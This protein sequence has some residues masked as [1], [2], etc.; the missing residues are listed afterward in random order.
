MV[1][2][3]SR[4]M[5]RVHGTAAIGARRSRWESP[6]SLRYWHTSSEEATG[7]SPICETNDN[8]GVDDPKYETLVNR[9][10]GQYKPN[11]IANSHPVHHESVESISDDS[12]YSLL[13]EQFASPSLPTRADEAI[14]QVSCRKKARSQDIAIVGMSCRFPGDATDP[15]KLW[16]L[17][18]QGREA[19]STWPTD[20]FNQ[21]AFYHP[22]PERGGNFNAKGGHFLNQVVA[23]FDASFFNITPA[24]AKAL[25]PQ[26]RLQ[27]ESTYE[28]LE[29]AGISLDTIAGSDTG[30]FIG[31]SNHDY[32][33]MLWKDPDGLPLYHAVGVS[34]S[35]MANRISY[36]F[37]LRGPSITVDTACSS[38]LV[39]LH[40][41]CQSLRSGEASQA[42]V[43]GTN[44]ILE[45]GM[46]IP[47]SSLKFF[48][49][50]GKCYTYDARAEGYGRG[51]GV[52]TVIIKLLDDAVRDGDTIRC[53]VRATGVNSD[54]RTAGLMLPNGDAQECLIR[55]TYASANLDPK[56]TQY[57]ESHGTGTKAGDPIESDVIGRIFGTPS[58]STDM[59]SVR[60]GSVKSN[61]GHLE[62]AS[63][64]AGLIKS[65]LSVERG[66]ILPNSNFE[67]PGDRIVL[68]ERNLRVPTRLEPWPTLGLRRSSVNSFG[69]GGT[70]AHCVID[71]AE[72][73][74]RLNGIFGHSLR[75]GDF[76]QVSSQPETCVE[77]RL[78]IYV[79]SANDEGT[80]HRYANTLGAHLNQSVQRHHQYADQL[81]YT[82]NS[83]R[84]LLPWRSAVVASS[85]SGLSQKLIHDDIKPQRCSRA[86]NLGFVFT[87]QG[88]Q[89]YGMGR[90]LLDAYPVYRR[91]IEI[92]S[93]HFKS[94]G[95]SWSLIE[96]L[97]RDQATSKL[98]YSSISQPVCTAVQLAIVDLLASWEIQPS[99]V[100]GHSS[101]EIAAAYAAG[102]LDSKSALAIAY[103]RGKAMEDLKR[104]APELRGTMLAAGISVSQA[105]EFIAKMGPSD[106]TVACI[107]SPSSVTISGD[108]E[109][110]E[111]MGQLLVDHK[112]FARRLNV[113]VAYHSDHMLYTSNEYL[114]NLLAGPKLPNNLHARQDVTFVSSLE[115]R[116]LDVSELGA[117]YWVR[118]MVSPVRF[119][120][121]LAEL[122]RGDEE[123]H[124]DTLIEVGPHS[125]LAG[126]IRQTLETLEL[127]KQVA[128][129]PT[130]IRYQNAHGSLLST[131]CDLWKMACP[132]DMN[133]VNRLEYPETKFGP[134]TDLPPYPFNHTI[135][136]WH[137]S[138]LSKA[139]R[140][141]KHGR[142]DL[143][144]A[145][146]P[147]SNPIEPKWRNVLRLTDVPWLKHHI[148]QSTVVYPAA[149]Y[150]AMAIEA[151]RQRTLMRSDPDTCIAQ[152]RLRNVSLIS[153]LVVPSGDAG[154]EVSL[155][156][157][158][159]SEGDR[160]LSNVWSEFMILSY[161]ESQ[162]WTEHCRGQIAA[163]VESRRS[164]RTEDAAMACIDDDCWLLKLQSQFQNCN[165]D[166]DPDNLYEMFE[167]MGLVFGSTFRNLKFVSV[168]APKTSRCGIIVPD[169][170]ATMPHRAEFFNTIHPAVLDSCFQAA[171]PVLMHDH[172]LSHPM[173]PTFI[174]QL[175][176]GS[177]A[178][179]DVGTKLKA[180]ATTEPLI[181]R[182]AVSDIAVFNVESS[183]MTRPTVL[184]KGLKTTALTWGSTPQE[185]EVRRKICYKMQYEPDIDF[186][187]TSDRSKFWPAPDSSREHQAAESLVIL[188]WLAF[189]YLSEC[190]K[191]IDE[192][193]YLEMPEH[194][195]RLYKWCR[196][197]APP[198]P[199]TKADNLSLSEAYSI[200][201]MPGSPA[202]KQAAIDFAQKLGAEGEIVTRVGENL[203]CILKGEVD[204]LSLMVQ[205]NLLTQVYAEDRSMLRCYELLQKYARSLCFKNPNMKIMEIGAGTGGATQPLL[206][207]LSTRE[208]EAFHP[209]FASYTYTDIS[210]AFFEKARSRFAA[211]D[212]VLEYRNLNIERSAAEQG[213]YEGTYD[214][215]VAA[216]VLHA[217]ANM[218]VTISNVRK[219]LRPGGRLI[220]IEITHPRLRIFLPFGTLPGWW[221]GEE[222]GR[223]MGP[224]LNPGQWSDV[225]KR[226]GFDGLDVCQADYPGP[227]EMSSLIVSRATASKPE[228]VGASPI[229][230]LTNSDQDPLAI[231]LRKSIQCGGSSSLILS[232][233]E[234]EGRRPESLIIL[235]TQ[236]DGMLSSLD[237][238]RFTK[239][240][241]TLRNSKGAVWVT[242]GATETRPAMALVSGLARTLR[243]EDAGLRL[244]TVDLDPKTIMDVTKARGII[245][246]VLEKLNDHE[247]SKDVEV[248][249]HD[250]V[251]CVPRLNAL[252]DL[253]HILT[254]KMTG[255]APLPRLEPLCQLNRP[256]RLQ[257]GNPG[258]IDSLHF[259]DVP[260]WEPH[261]DDGCVEVQVKAIGLNFRDVLTVLGQIENPYPLGYDSSGVITAVGR[262]V[263]D[264]AVGDR[265]AALAVGSFT[266]VHRVRAHN[267]FHL[268]PGIS[269][270][271]GASIPL[272]FATA[273]H[274]LVDVAHVSKGQKVL[275][276]SAAGGVGQAAI[277]LAQLASAEIFVTVGSKEK[278]QL[279]LEEY[280][281]PESHIFS[282]R[283]AGFAERIRLMTDGKGVDVVLNSLAGELMKES[284]NCIAMFG[285][286]L[287]IGKRDIYSN[288]RL[289][290]R[291]FDNHVTFAAIDLSA[292]FTHRPEWGA[293]ILGNCFKL[294]H[295]G[296]LSVMKPVTTFSIDQVETAFRH[297]QA[298][299]HSGKIVVTVPEG[300]HV[301]A[302]PMA[303]SSF[304]EADATYII[305]GGMG[306]LGREICQ[307]MVDNGAENILILSRSGVHENEKARDLLDACAAKGANVKVCK[308]DARDATA[309]AKILRDSRDK[310]CMPPIRGVI[311]G[312]MVLRDSLFE[313]MAFDD[314]KT[315]TDTKVSST[316]NLH[317]A[318]QALDSP[319]DFFILLSS[320]SGISG[321]RGQSNYAAASTFQ[322]AFARHRRSLGLP[323]TTLDLGMIASAGYV[324]DN[325][326]SV[327]YLRAHGYSAIELEE[328]FGML[329]Y[330]MTQRPQSATDSTASGSVHECQIISGYDAT[331]ATHVTALSSAVSDT[332]TASHRRAN[333]GAGASVGLADPKFSHLPH[334][335]HQRSPPTLRHADPSSSPSAFSSAE[336]SL[337]LRQALLATPRGPART[338]VLTRALATRL[339]ALLGKSG[340][341]A[342][343]DPGR[344]VAMLGVDSLVAVELRN[345]VVGET[346]VGVPVFE[347]LGAK[348]LVELS[349]RIEGACAFLGDTG[350]G[351][352]RR[353]DSEDY[354]D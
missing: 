236:G 118:N 53:V 138:R 63:G 67:K 199:P 267:V 291:P 244:M 119:T 97:S 214:L 346:G 278:R 208:G 285:F 292:V 310:G 43:G 249:E 340:G 351:D 41:A 141:R 163:D 179:R 218:D 212:D 299:K 253:N 27:L 164:E 221:L 327:A 18:A 321:N 202:K 64:I 61:I 234:L 294:F 195:K 117:S 288:T 303:E 329:R 339:A 89:W 305:A 256:L 308:C 223:E 120:E 96:E 139:Y 131:A 112:L 21:D 161:T 183:V 85:I 79:I 69:F 20:R 230:I 217:T 151:A 33:H 99:A 123:H 36:F 352:G 187:S 51:E 248:I 213:L 233:N 302:A 159:A 111:K 232:W 130:L 172:R 188:E 307:W 34:A 271:D 240:R 31:T 353:E 101:G 226:N 132:V 177:D 228:V 235:D 349:V 155:S 259:G 239:I 210:S 284:W 15:G 39:A 22:N 181:L 342:D 193:D 176:V 2:D 95:S 124:I 148:V 265:V 68:T 137:E 283:N 58:A 328:L 125:T 42:I 3:E 49:P 293:K 319:L 80:A 110:I 263:G 330:A 165:K 93:E 287:E 215:I 30:V 300:V 38:S 277:K 325:T 88:A 286:F 334:I 338:A 103:Y 225:L 12:S 157:R 52:G 11:G 71:D 166:L 136:H 190:L 145:L 167:E 282:S 37:D 207:A 28:A 76:Q 135:S 205:D 309:V 44:L 143:L 6:K 245:S 260:K 46:L 84:S 128:Y 59:P 113:D 178:P 16:D 66:L 261:L 220:L 19:W 204:P 175:T 54:G 301:M 211:W 122:F 316:W 82:L 158:S 81:A 341:A 258:S 47:M 196:L 98:D 206:E 289:E 246:K 73:F 200:M 14:A 296:K 9:C 107:N 336:P 331:A 243:N 1:Q 280:H 324:A 169:T 251:I 219:L 203:P 194:H 152:Y 274:A 269:F 229:Y 55:S 94:L 252:H 144:G 266:N 105:R 201:N 7:N 72:N 335:H 184:I 224:L 65:V 108:E 313:N 227:Y 23:G 13:D 32:E 304:L 314:W 354:G 231:G 306:G 170:A 121:A 142:H 90:E 264:F 160:E 322:D 189:Q 273:Y 153:A 25:D 156:L 29:N 337:P 70:N 186:A 74:L 50:E 24:E 4:S 185:L 180:F 333:A 102:A 318:T 147:D 87:G 140:F 35:I 116:A 343:V 255:A 86:P 106:L 133:E 8:V 146:V 262:N 77:G 241:N 5:K 298:G 312:A 127:K 347:M 320:A 40:Q 48:S 100:I 326:D 315:V 114:A 317:N 209:L 75:A 171:F 254:H 162:G 78:R 109:A 115:A 247:F 129:L 222:D 268:P 192:E 154:V 17:C 92:A 91:T 344:S 150:I 174:E 270:E 297:M 276:H 191:C 332:G 182:N 62:N 134:L 348:S 279:M 45:P 26:Q 198:E 173:V 237:E 281:I 126:P 311:N 257:V 197:Q 323:A 295:E 57:V 10:R 149:A 345:W 275:I 104:V 290:M 83:R 216:N 242:A 350:E 168:G 272:A 238:T 60:V 56:L 250:G